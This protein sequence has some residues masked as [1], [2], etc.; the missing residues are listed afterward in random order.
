MPLFSISKTKLSTVDQANFSAEKDLHTL[1][2]ENH[3]F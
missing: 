3:G 1:I 2:E